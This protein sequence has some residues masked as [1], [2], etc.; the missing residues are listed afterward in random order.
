MTTTMRNGNFFCTCC[1]S[2]FKLTMPLP[3]SEYT[4]KMDAFNVLHK[5]CDQTWEE[6]KPDFNTGLYERANWWWINGE[7]GLSSE[8]M[9]HC[10]MDEEILNIN[11]P[12]DPD[13]FS[14][15][16][17]LLEAVPEWKG[18]IPELKDL[19]WQWANLVDNWD[20]LNDFYEDMRKS[21]K[22]NGMY[23]FMQELISKQE[24]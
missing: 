21:K 13:D 23:Q 24:G 7:R 1:G 17:K 15:C 16:Y 3:I 10:L 6:P 4:K 11:H 5:D 14:R 19:S 12:L 2:E 8:T 18:R 22:G 20:K 9:W